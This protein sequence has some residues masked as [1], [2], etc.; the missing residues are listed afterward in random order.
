MQAIGKMR[1]EIPEST[2]L[3]ESTETAALWFT[4]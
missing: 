3:P 4:P 2:I 1:G